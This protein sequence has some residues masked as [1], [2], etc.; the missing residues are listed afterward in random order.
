MAS[1]KG[2]FE[3]KP[4]E[5][6]SP[7]RA[8]YLDIQQGNMRELYRTYRKR[9]EQ[10]LRDMEAAGMSHLEAYTDNKNRFP[11]LKEI[12]SGQSTNK[13]LLYD[14]MSEVTRF[15][16]LRDST[17]GSYH[18][19][20]RQSEETFK[21]HYGE[22]FEGLT[23]SQAALGELMESIRQSVRAQAYYR[24][25]KKAYR[26]VLSNAQKAG[27]TGASLEKAIKGGAVRIGAG[28]GLIDT[29]SGK[30]IQGKWAKMGN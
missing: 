17:P 30:Y 18:E 26:K 29:G 3:R 24:G 16:N 28:G 5:V 8:R 11:T 23:L 21:R 4:V 6:L 15:L 10:R 9:A 27:F 25:W 1:G 12:G 22:E 7:E 2:R 20:L 13:Q 19:R 14:A